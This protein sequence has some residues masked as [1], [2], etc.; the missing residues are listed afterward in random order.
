MPVAT[1][2]QDSSHRQSQFPT[3]HPCSGRYILTHVGSSCYVAQAYCSLTSWPEW[4]ALHTKTGSTLDA[5]LSEEV[6]CHWGAV[7]GIISNNDTR[8][9]TSLDWFTDRCSIRHIRIFIYNPRANGVVEW[10]NRTICEPLIK[11]CDGDLSKWP[12]CVPHVFWAYR[13]TSRKP[14]GHSPFYM[15]YGI[16]RLLLFDIMLAMFLV[17]E[18]TKPLPTAD[19]IATRACQLEVHESDLATI[20]QNV[21]KSC[22]TSVRQFRPRAEDQA[23]LL[24]LWPYGCC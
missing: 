18:L 3:P 10:Q 6:L 9:V 17:P 1:D 20:H 15:A 13:A 19:F 4:R 21:L 22:L 5:F 11:A 2:H 16:E 8:Y 14:T 7:D 23:P 12:V 24:V